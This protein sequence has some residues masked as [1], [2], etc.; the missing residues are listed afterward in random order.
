MWRRT[1]LA[2][3]LERRTNDADAGVSDVDARR[4]Y[5]A[6]TARARSEV[7]VAQ[8]LLRDEAAA[9]PAPRS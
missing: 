5:E 8:I 3:L 9:P 7:R 2:A 6:N 4:W 1:Q